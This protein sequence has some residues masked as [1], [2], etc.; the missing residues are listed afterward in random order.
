MD[1]T[2]RIKKLLGSGL[3]PSVVAEAVGVS[4][5]YISQLMEHQEFSDAVT[6]AR[7]TKAEAAVARDSRWDAIE[8]KVL[9]KAESMLPMVTRVR[10]LVAIGQIANNAKRRA[11]EFAGVENTHAPMVTINM[12]NAAVVHF[13]MNPN[14]QVIAVEGR[15]MLPLPTQN[16]QKHLQQMKEEREAAGIV[17]VSVNTPARLSEKK[18]VESI[19]EQIGYAE[20]AVPVPSIMQTVAVSAN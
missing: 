16:L 17:D 2:E 9:E 5:A 11:A 4:P 10:D 12:P 1:T 15:S 19:L 20:E 14:A 13:Q 18:K 3:P 8:D 7:A 6:L